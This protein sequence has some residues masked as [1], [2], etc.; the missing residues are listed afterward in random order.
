MDE[1]Q[2]GKMSINKK[3]EHTLTLFALIS[4]NVAVIFDLGISAWIV[5]GRY[6]GLAFVDVNGGRA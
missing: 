5:G 2:P 3:C 6:A 1:I 4:E